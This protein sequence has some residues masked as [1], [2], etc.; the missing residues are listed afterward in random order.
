MKLASSHHHWSRNR[1]G[2]IGAGARHELNTT[3]EVS[4][5]MPHRR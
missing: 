3:Q 4:Q 2:K 5:G 1:V